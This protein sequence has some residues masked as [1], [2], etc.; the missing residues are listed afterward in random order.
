MRTIIMILALLLLVGVAA[1]QTPYL[2]CGH[3]YDEEGA[4]SEGIEVTLL[5]QRTG[6]TQTF[7]T[8]E[9]GEYLIDCLN[10]KQ[11]FQNKDAITISCTYDSIN[12]II[13]TD[14][15]G[16][17]ADMNRPDDIDPVPIIA[18]TILVAAAG[19]AYFY[20]KRRGK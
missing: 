2:L 10:Y 5:N 8:N 13:N 1:A 9:R 15:E 16:I 20:L 18:G 7:I 17:Q 3:V 14:Y 12:A 6:E 11:G 4:L 19:G